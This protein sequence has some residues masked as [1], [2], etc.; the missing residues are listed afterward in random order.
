MINM[1]LKDMLRMYAMH[2][3]WKWEKYLSLVEFAYNN[4]YQESLNMS[5]FEALFGWS[6]NT[7]ISCS[8]PMNWMLIGTDTLV[9]MKEEM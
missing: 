4:R 6:Y 2:Q 3:Q 7:P 8:D 5:L 9:E 1:I